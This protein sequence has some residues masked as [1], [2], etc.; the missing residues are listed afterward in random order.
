MDDF[1]EILDHKINRDLSNSYFS[2]GEDR[3]FL[4]TA[5]T[6]ALYSTPFNTMDDTWFNS[7]VEQW[8]QNDFLKTLL[9]GN[10]SFE[11]TPE[12]K[13]YIIDIHTKEG[14][15]ANKTKKDFVTVGAVV[16]PQSQIYYNEALA[17]VYTDFNG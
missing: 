16:N 7:I 10:Y 3:P 15:T 2:I 8:R 6:A 11:I 9:R 5:F 13:S 4:M 17:K 12:E 1:G 14:R